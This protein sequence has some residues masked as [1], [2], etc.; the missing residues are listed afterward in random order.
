[1]PIRVTHEIK[2]CL[3]KIHRM[4]HALAPKPFAPCYF[5]RV[6]HAD[7]VTSLLQKTQHMGG[8]VHSNLMNLH[9]HHDEVILLI[10]APFYGASNARQCAGGVL[11]LLYVDPSSSVHAHPLSR[12]F[13]T[14]VCSSAN[15]DSVSRENR[16]RW[17]MKRNVDSCVLRIERSDM[18]GH[19]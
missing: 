16:G 18:V 6:T 5:N 11:F 19:M 9:G 7:I 3:V 4:N 1:M 15:F 2:G 14:L 13:S 8:W 10:G 17:F 12:G